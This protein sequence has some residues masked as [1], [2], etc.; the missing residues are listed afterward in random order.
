M[1]YLVKIKFKEKRLVIIK[2]LKVQRS[3]SKITFDCFLMILEKQL[4]IYDD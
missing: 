1:S 2:K 3:K 4:I